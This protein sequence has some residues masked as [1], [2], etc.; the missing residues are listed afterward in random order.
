[1]HNDTTTIISFWKAHWG[2]VIGV[3]LALLLGLAG[4]ACLRAPGRLVARWSGRHGRPVRAQ[5]F[6]ALTAPLVAAI[7]GVSL[8]FAALA[9]AAP[10]GAGGVFTG[11]PVTLQVYMLLVIAWAGLRVTKVIEHGYPDHVRLRH[12][13]APDPMLVDALAKIARILIVTIIGLMTLRVLNFSIA[14]LLAFGGVAGVAVGFAAQGV[15]ANLFGAL[16][17]YLDQPFKVGEW[18]VLPAQNVFGTV[19]HIGWRTTTLR[20]F[21]TRPYYVPNQIFNTSVVQTPPRMQAR[22]I[23]ETLSI[24]YA[25]F[26]K[27][28]AIVEDCRQHVAAHPE[29]DHSQGD[30]V[31]FSKYGTHALEIMIYCFARTQVWKE[32]LAIQERLLID[33]GEI[34]RR[35]GAQLAVPISQV[36]ITSRAPM[37]PGLAAAAQWG[38][39]A[40]V[41][42]P[43]ASGR[44][45]PAP[46]LR[47]RP[48]TPPPAPARARLWCHAP[49]P[50]GSGSPPPRRRRA[51]SGT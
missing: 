6:L 41:R 11:S 32:S 21:D 12:G 20:G 29:I 47:R 37:E 26:P 33:L 13:H 5:V 38:R 19:E 3:G 40:G 18:I 25:D 39:C 46:A 17:V 22:R 2:T 7:W 23:S 30:M 10:F 16:V 50:G 28:A 24:R 45:P 1:M 4:T 51:A 36:E 48:P 42:E 31:Y 35:H 15:T 34:V 27:L 43:A 9:L 8:H 44:A 14:S 49:R